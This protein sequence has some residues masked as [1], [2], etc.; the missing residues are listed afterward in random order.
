[1]RTAHSENKE[2]VHHTNKKDVTTHLWCVVTDFKKMLVLTGVEQAVQYGEKVANSLIGI[3]GLKKPAK[4]RWLRKNKI[5]KL[6]KGGN[7]L[8]R[9]N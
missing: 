2:Y 4:D 1:M 7:P 6:I 3:C 8:F 5:A 9:G